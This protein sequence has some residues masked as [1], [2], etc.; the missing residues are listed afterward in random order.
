LP[1]QQS[2]FSTQDSFS[3]LQH[4]SVSP[5]M[6]QARPG[7]QIMLPGVPTTVSHGWP[8]RAQAIR[9]RA[10]ASASLPPRRRIATPLS[11]AAAAPLSNPRRDV[12]RD[13]SFVS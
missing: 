7:Q 9:T 8:S 5:F 6:S 10:R 12:E 11:A 4:D 1:A 3:G 2:V 13:T